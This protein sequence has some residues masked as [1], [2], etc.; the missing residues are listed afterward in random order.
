MNFINVRVEYVVKNEDGIKIIAE[1]EGAISFTSVGGSGIPGDFDGDGSVSLIE[2]SDVIDMFGK[3]T[4]SIDWSLCKFCD[5][6]NNGE[7]DILD[8][9]AIAK[10]IA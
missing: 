9:S 5:I 10:H 7:I 4:E 8:I 1:A 6:N 2:L 3:N